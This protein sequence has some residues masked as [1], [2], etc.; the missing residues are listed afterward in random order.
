MSWLQTL[1]SKHPQM[2]PPDISSTINESGIPTLS[3]LYHTNKL[4]PNSR[5]IFPPNSI[6]NSKIRL[7]C[8]DITRLHLPNGAIVNAANEALI[9]G[10]GVCGA[11]HSAAG[12]E[13]AL[14]CRVHYHHGCETGHAVITRAYKLLCKYVIHAVGPVYWLTKPL[15]THAVL[16][17]RCYSEVLKL[18]VDNELTSVAFCA[19]S[20]GVYGYPSYEAAESALKAVRKFLETE[21]GKK[22]ESVIFCNFEKK[23]QD[24][25]LDLIP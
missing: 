12:P 7:I 11:I 21:E 13:L 20:T 9:T 5:P 6:I 10:G 8:T 24:A 15:N 23:D 3:L 2:S 19:L 25:Y 16:L 1:V 4:T 14:E 18:C 22:M 17:E